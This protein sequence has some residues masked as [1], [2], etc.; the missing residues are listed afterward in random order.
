VQGMF[1]APFAVF[2]EFNFSFNLLFIFLGIV[3]DPTANRTL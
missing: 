3:I 2:F 1:P